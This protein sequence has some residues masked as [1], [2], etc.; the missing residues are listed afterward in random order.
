MD[1]AVADADAAMRTR[2]SHAIEYRDGLII[3]FLAL[4]PLRSRTF[5]ALRIGRHLEKAGDLWELEIPAADTKT[6]RPLDYTISKELSA[7]IDLHLERFRRRIPGSDKHSSLWS[8]IQSRPMC[9]D[10]IYGAVYRRTK[11]AFGFG[12][13][14]HRFRSAAA[15]F[16]S[17][18]DPANVRGAKDLLGH[19]SFRTTERHYIMTQSRLAGRALARAIDNVKLPR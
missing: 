14:L 7:R 3:S 15:S 1:R 18:H 10:A 6:R 2:M 4:R 12:V 13:N 9:S 11:A 19:A 17:I 8:S 16:W 5:A